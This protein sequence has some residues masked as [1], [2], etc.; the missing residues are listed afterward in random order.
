[1]FDSF[2]VGIGVVQLV[3]ERCSVS[4][5]FCFIEFNVVL[6]NKFLVVLDA[7]EFI[8]RNF[9]SIFNVISAVSSPSGRAIFASAARLICLASGILLIK[10]HGRAR[11]GQGIP[12]CFV[13]I[14]LVGWEWEGSQI[15][16]SNEIAIPLV[17]FIT[18][19]RPSTLGF[20]IRIAGTEVHA[21]FYEWLGGSRLNLFPSKPRDVELAGNL[22]NNLVVEIPQRSGQ[23]RHIDIVVEGCLVRLPRRCTVHIEGVEWC[24]ASSF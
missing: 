8:D 21:Q 19:P 4:L 6:G 17:V 2:I 7:L 15:V 11:S 18:T 3:P 20:V 16:A 24:F 5:V 23:V 1:M 14:Y 9:S 10:R 13:I 12:F 22:P